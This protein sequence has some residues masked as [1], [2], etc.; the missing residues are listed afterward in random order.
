MHK[1]NAPEDP[2]PPTHTPPNN[3]IISI[4]APGH[5]RSPPPL[6]LGP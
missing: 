5:A 3:N 2:H 4:Q 6:S 1:L